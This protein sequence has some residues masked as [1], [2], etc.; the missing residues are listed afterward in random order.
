MGR[1]DILLVGGFPEVI[2]LCELCDVNIVGI[3][4]PTSDSQIRGIPVV[5][6][7][8]DAHQ[9][10]AAFSSVPVLLGVDR[11]DRRQQLAAIYTAAGF[12]FFSL[13]SPHAQISP[14]ARIGAG[15]TIQ[16]GCHVSTNAVL[17]DFVRLNVGATVMHDC[18]VA[19]FATLAPGALLLGT[20]TV[21][22]GS[23]VGAHATVI[24]TRTIGQGAVIG[25]GAVVTKNVMDSQTVAGVPAQPLS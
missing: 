17:G 12:E 9:L 5:G 19:D 15:V 23:Y 25:A 22:R 4:D 6:T 21:G 2:E 8:D 18:Q 11:P 14:S 20:V 13:I 7:D 24:Q 1:P 3:V 16:S 10:G